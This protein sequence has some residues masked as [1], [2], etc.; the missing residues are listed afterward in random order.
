M[1]TLY[2]LRFRPLFRRYLWGGR[3]LG[4]LLGKPIADGDDYAESWE[5]C[6]RGTDQSI[7]AFGPLTGATLG[8]LVKTRGRELL[9]RH[10]PQK[11][12]PL[13]FKFLDARLPLS[14]QVHPDDARAALLAPAEFGKTEAWIVLHAEADSVIYA[15]LKPGVD[16]QAL[17]AAI[18]RG[19]C[20][21]CLHR[22]TP[23]PGDCVFLPAGV[24]HALGGGLVVAEIQQSSDTTWRLFDWNRA[25]PDGRPRPLHVDEALEAIDFS[26]GP[27]S[28]V[29]PQATDR[30][31]IERLVGCD[32]FVV[33]RHRDR[34][35]WRLPDDQRCHIVSALAGEVTIAGDPSKLPLTVGDTALVPAERAAT[36]VIPGSGAVVLDIFLP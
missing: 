10:A 7:V 34:A 32:K 17:V 12:F 27:V 30:H 28:P 8:D 21:D 6:D 22:F 18:D 3:K 19:A 33:D 5:I 23:R 24:V 35:P 4:T 31:E 26:I 9:G 29:A 20:D 25:G 11:R 14:V 16:R 2:P 13:L 1:T 15:G 36:E